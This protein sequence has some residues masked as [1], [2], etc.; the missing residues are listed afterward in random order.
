MRPTSTTLSRELVIQHPLPH[1]MPSHLH[2]ARFKVF[3]W[4]RR[5]GK[6]RE[7]F[8]AGMTG[9]GPG[10]L[11]GTPQHPGVLGGWDVVWVGKDYPQ[12]RQIWMEEIRPR[13]DN[14]EGVRIIESPY[15]AV[16]IDGHGTLHVRSAENIESVRGVGAKLKGVIVDEGAHLDLGYAWQN[17]LRPVLMDNKGW[18][19]LMSTTNSGLDGNIEKIAPS[20]FNRL[21]ADIMAVKPGRT[22]EDGWFHSYLTARE[23]PKIDAEEWDATVREYPAESIA[24]AEELEAKLLAAGAGLAFPEWRDDVHVQRR[25]PPANWVWFGGMDWGYSDHCACYALASGGDREIMVR[26]EWYEKEID[27]YTT[28]YRIGEQLKQF[29]RLEWIGCD[30]SMANVTDGGMTIMERIQKGLIDSMGKQHHPVLVTV[31][32]GPGSR[33][34]RKQLLHEVLRYEEREE[35]G[36]KVVPPWLAPRLTVHPSCSNLIRTLPALPRDPNPRKTEDVDTLAE[37]HAY[38]ALTYP[39]LARAQVKQVDPAR[40]L[41]ASQDH[42]GGWTMVNGVRQEKNAWQKSPLTGRA[43][44]RTGVKWRRANPGED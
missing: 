36:H 44:Y 2:S 28:G 22:E 24:L 7:A 18:A 43:P 37:D 21:C 25:E 11:E 32:K 30:S 4:G 41:P 5:T 38:D 12:A 19:I 34:T 26:W 42:H 9:H 39:L 1:Q 16:L 29:P 13:F 27:P 10:W 31:P 6:T 14:V 35:N 15:Y 40:D 23:N 17:V 20:Y 3:R 33:G 8:I